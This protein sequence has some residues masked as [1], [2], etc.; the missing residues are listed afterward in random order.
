MIAFTYQLDINKVD[1]EG[2]P[3]AGAE[4]SLEKLVKGAMDADDKYEAVKTI[5]NGGGDSK[6]VFT[7]T[8][9]DDGTYRLTETKAPEGYVAAS[10]VTFTVTADHNVVWDYTSDAASD[11]AFS[12][13]GRADILNGLTGELTDGKLKIADGETLKTLEVGS[14]TDWVG[15]ESLAAYVE[16]TPGAT[17]VKGA[18]QVKKTVVSTRGEDKEREYDFKVT[19]YYNEKDQSDG[20]IA[21][22]VNGKYGDLEFKDGVATFTLK[23]NETKKATDLPVDE[24]P[25]LAWGAEETDSKGLTPSGGLERT[26]LDGTKSRTFTNTYTAPKDSA[27]S[28]TSSKT[29]TPKTSDDTNFVPAAVI[30]VAGAAIVAGGIVYRKRKNQ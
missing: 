10:P 4:F 1:S 15:T 5:A 17:P 26:L 9:L 2:K 14:K 7:A 28:A 22:A 6:N 24:Y 21:T 3:L 30:A 20:N 19:L 16:N 18:I 27:S 13:D 23:H 25:E 12:P 11:P 8:G 29:S